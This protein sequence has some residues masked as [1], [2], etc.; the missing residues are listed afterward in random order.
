[1]NKVILI[2][3]FFTVSF[4]SVTNANEQSLF[5]SASEIKDF[6]CNSEYINIINNDFSSP[7]SSYLIPRAGDSSMG[8]YRGYSSYSVGESDIFSFTEDSNSYV[9][10]ANYNGESW[11]IDSSETRILFY[12]FDNRYDMPTNLPKG[13]SYLDIEFDYRFYSDEKSMLYFNEDDVL[14]EIGTR[15][16]A[17]ERTGEINLNQITKNNSDDFSWHHIS[18]RVNLSASSNS[19]SMYIKFKYK[20]IPQSLSPKFYID[21]DNVKAI[22]NNR[23]Y[24]YKDGKFD[25]LKT[26]INLPSY[27]S[28]SA[29]FN[30]NIYYQESLGLSPYISHGFLNLEGKGRNLTFSN[31]LNFTSTPRVIRFAFD[32]VQNSTNK[33]SLLF[34]DK[35][36]FK[37]HLDEMN[38]DFVHSVFEDNKFIAYIN[39][40]AFANISSISLIQHDGEAKID[41]LTIGVVKAVNLT[42]GNYDEFLLFKN[43]KEQLFEN[44]KKKYIPASCVDIFDFLK[45][46]NEVTL[47]SSQK[48]I[49]QTVAEFNIIFCSLIRRG[50]I[51]DLRNYINSLFDQISGLNADDFEFVTWISFR[52]AVVEAY[53]LKEGC[54]DE[55][56]NSATNQVRDAFNNLRR[57][58]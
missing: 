27:P 24:I 5:L 26:N 49:N 41:N 29:F 12:W 1:M 51:E 47:N 34:N 15:G 58:S 53:S 13:I 17:N 31:S 6:D 37:S 50:N 35:E 39:A 28:P 40:S 2:L 44:Y 7:C 22:Y 16:S 48:I 43:E 38:N 56:L 57:V 54:T 18:K 21:I 10:M 33:Y 45:K 42:R 55:E 32:I 20:N 46:L 14:L 9:R 11:G 23:N 8:Y 30:E 25:E 3:S 52:N 19:T 4:A 36:I